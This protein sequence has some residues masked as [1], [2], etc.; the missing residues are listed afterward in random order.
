VKNNNPMLAIKLSQKVGPVA[1][2]IV[3]ALA[4]AGKIEAGAVI[5]ATEITQLLNFGQLSAQY[6]EQVEMVVK[7]AE[8]IQNQLNAYALQ[9]QNTQQLTGL[10]WT[11]ASAD[12]NELAQIAQTGANVSYTYAAQDTAYTALHHSYADYL[13]Q[14]PA[15]P[16][17]ATYQQWSAYNL[18][19][20]TRAANA[21]GMTFA[22]ASDEQSRIAAL[23]TAGANPTGEVQAVMAGNAL[24]AEM[25]DQ[26]RQLK[27]LMAQQMDSQ[28]R[29]QRIEEEKKAQAAAAIQNV[30]TPPTNTGT[31]D[32][33]YGAMPNN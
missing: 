28:A 31:T 4:T 25:L 6:A 33:S 27:L 29:Y 24:A 12:I 32:A 10:Q 2:V 5:G 30:S 15:A 7:Q 21:A 14:N 11:N 3:I 26:M 19:A 17:P 18:D 1:L 23:K 22:Q 9:L 20:A 16:T 13:A 8:Q